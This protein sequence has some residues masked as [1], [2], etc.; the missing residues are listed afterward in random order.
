MKQKKLVI[1]VLTFAELAAK[2][3]IKLSIK[4]CVLLAESLLLQSTPKLFYQRMLSALH[5]GCS[6]LCYCKL[7]ELIN[8]NIICIA[9]NIFILCFE[10][11]IISFLFGTKQK[12]LSYIEGQ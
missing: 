3:G 7:K 8:K 12:I 11:T 4:S 10:N 1:T 9:K 5:D 6:T 2:V